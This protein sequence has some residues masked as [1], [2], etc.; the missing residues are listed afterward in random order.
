MSGPAPPLIRQA[1]A[2]DTPVLEALIARSAR[3]LSRSDYSADEIEALIEHVFGIDSE[4]VADGLVIA[5]GARARTLP[6]LSGPRGVHTLRTVDDAVALRDDLAGARSLVVVGG[7]FIGAEVASSAAELGLAVTVVEAMPTPLAGPLGPELGAACAA[8]HTDHGVRLLTGHAVARL[9]GDDRVTGVELADGTQ[10]PADVVLVGVDSQP[11]VE[12]LAGSGIEI[13]GPEVGG[14]VLTDASCATNVPGVV[15]VGDCASSYDPAVSSH[16][17]IEHWTHALQQPATAAATLLGASAPAYSEV[18][19]FWSEQY[20]THLQF[21]GTH[22]AGDLVT[23]VS[24]S[25]DSRSFV[26]TCERDGRLVGVLG[27]GSPGPFGRWR[28]TLRTEHRARAS[29]GVRA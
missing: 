9:L 26:A 20:G 3:G 28:R 13:G 24:G 18:P 15:A 11:D 23:I 4:V 21:A 12:W 7:G 5:T 1:T 6:A 25:T 17:R 8:L 22:Q 10:L 27:L 14:G 16:R 2:A 19:Y 29:Q